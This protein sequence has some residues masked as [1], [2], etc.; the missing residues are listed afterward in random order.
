MLSMRLAKLRAMLHGSN[1]PALMMVAVCC[2]IGAIFPGLDPVAAL[3]R[4]GGGD[5]GDGSSFKPA[6]GGFRSRTLQMNGGV[7]SDDSGLFALFGVAGMQFW[8][9]AAAV[10]LFTVAVA[11]MATS[12]GSPTSVMAPSPTCKPPAS[13]TI[14][15]SKPSSVP[16]SLAA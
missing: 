4:S 16:R 11:V 8:L 15:G 2:G 3:H 9:L 5:G 7:G 6:S 12:S 10:V 1:G 14:G 13:G